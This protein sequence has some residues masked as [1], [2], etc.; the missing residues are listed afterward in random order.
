MNKAFYYKLLQIIIIV[1]I[2]TV[3]A[4]SLFRGYREPKV[5]VSSESFNVQSPW[6]ITVPVADIASADTISWKEMPIITLRTNGISLLGVN[7]GRFNTENGNNVW[8]SVKSGVS[9]V[10]Q[11][12][13]K[14]GKTYY[15]N[16]KNPDETRNIF[17]LLTNYLK[18]RK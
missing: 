8:L 6:S 12:V 18:D 14:N 7:R 4:I 9:P 10:I 17:Y 5:T 2:L 1:V 13:D 16:R 3:V 11:I 15:L